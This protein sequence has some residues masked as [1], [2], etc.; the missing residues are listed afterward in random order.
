VNI[1]DNAIVGASSEYSPPVEIGDNVSIGHGVV[2]K[3]STI[4]NNALI[5]INAV[6][7][8]GAKVGFHAA[9]GKARSLAF[10]F[11][12]ATCFV[13]GLQVGGLS[14]IAA[15]SYVEENT[16]V[17]SGE[18]WAGNPAKKLRDLK[19]QEREHLQQLPAKYT[20]M[21]AQH[22]QVCAPAIAEQGAVVTVQLCL[23]SADLM[24][25]LPGGMQVMALLRMKQEEYTS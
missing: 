19:P 3:G 6:I 10:A 20:S 14:I 12:C 24:P 23:G 11:T 4:G 2:I 8:E 16:T 13:F 18:V 21:A 5:G 17:P 7:S 22:E 15:G 9:N 1:Q 25:I